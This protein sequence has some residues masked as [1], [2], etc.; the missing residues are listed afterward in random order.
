MTMGWRLGL[1]WLA[2]V[3]SL[4]CLLL[5]AQRTRSPFDDPDPARQRPGMLDAGEPRPIAPPVAPGFP[6]TGRRAVV[7]FVDRDLGGPLCRAVGNTGTL[8]RHAEVAIV[9]P[10]GIV[11][12][13]AARAVIDT[14]GALARAFGIPRPRGGG[15]RIGYAVIDEAGRIRYRTLDPTVI[16]HLGEVET[17][18]R[19]VP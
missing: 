11:S 17:I 15:S 19:A 1:L 12:C 18:L 2:V 14:A 16:D 10:E 6:A 4:G 7:F 13:P 3:A 9:S 5:V 8:Q